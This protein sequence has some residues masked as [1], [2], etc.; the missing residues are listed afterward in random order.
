[1]SIR[2]FL[3]ISV[4]FIPLCLLAQ[5]NELLRETIRT[6]CV[7]RNA[8]WNTLPYLELGTRDFL[9]ISFDDLDREYCRYRYR[10]EPMNWDWTPNSRLLSS[11]FL[12]RGFGDEPIDNFEESINTNVL[13]THYSFRF[14]NEN[15]AF[16]LSGNYRLVVYD[17]DEGEDVAV[18]P[19]YVVENGASVSV[20]VDTNTDIDFNDKHQ[21]LTF[22][23]QPMPSLGVHYPE[24]EIHTVVMQ[25]C[26]PLS[27]VYDPKPDYVT[28]TGLQWQH[29]DELIFLA[30]N[31]FH[32]FEMTTLRY[33]GMGMANIRWHDPYYHA[34]LLTDKTGRNYVYDEDNNG[35]F[36]IKTIDYD[37]GNIE[38]EYVWVHFSLKAQPEL[39]GKIY[40]D[41]AFTNHLLSPET[42]MTYNP[43]SQCYEAAILMKQGYYNYQYVFVSNENNHISLQ[44]TQGNFYQTQ[45]RYSVFAYYSQRGS[46]SDRLIAI[47]DFEFLSSHK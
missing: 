37:N 5:R 13:Y 26:S 24:T 14:P 46:R 27:A 36:L 15:I 42:E 17:D 33:G 41:G 6:L 39:N 4:L 30:G 28:P 9:S 10:I 45:N 23:L 19:F 47:S 7:E 3:T 16:K 20:G 1:M 21:Q 43:T 35:A 40:V 8:K 2:K 18:I 12:A 25:N 22:S 31:E 32:K 34:T 11:E 44:E 38:G 29:V